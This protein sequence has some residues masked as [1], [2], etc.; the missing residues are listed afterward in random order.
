MPPRLLAYAP[1]EEWSAVF[2]DCGRRSPGSRG[3]KEFGLGCGECDL[4]DTQE[5]MWCSS[6]ILE[7]GV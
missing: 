3:E 2:K 5:V 6:K 7:S 1:G 4:L